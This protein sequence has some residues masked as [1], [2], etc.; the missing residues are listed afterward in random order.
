MKR[1]S[2]EI[3]VTMVALHGMLPK[4]GIPIAIRPTIQE[5]LRQVKLQSTE[6]IVTMAVLVGG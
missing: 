3:T 1:R 5:W 6:P 2:T 4:T